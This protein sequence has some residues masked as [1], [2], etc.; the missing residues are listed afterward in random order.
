MDRNEMDAEAKKARE[1][2]RREK[3]TTKR[4]RSAFDVADEQAMESTDAYNARA[5]ARNA[6]Q[7]DN[8]GGMLGKAQRSLKERK[9]RLEEAEKKAK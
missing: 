5:A 7:N 1:A 9:Y 2:E 6:P 3:L 4:T 8:R